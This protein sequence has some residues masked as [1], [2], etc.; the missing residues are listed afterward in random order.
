VLRNKA[1][2]KNRE[3]EKEKGMQTFEKGAAVLRPN[4]SAVVAYLFQV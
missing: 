1:N 4:T 3:G 2:F